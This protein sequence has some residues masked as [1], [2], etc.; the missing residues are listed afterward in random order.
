[1]SRMEGPVKS[2]TRQWLAA[3]SGAALAGHG[4]PRRDQRGLRGQ[5]AATTE[6]PGFAEK[7]AHNF[8]RSFFEHHSKRCNS[9]DANTRFEEAAGELRAK[10]ARMLRKRRHCCWILQ[11]MHQ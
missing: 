5:Q 8:P 11:V 2:C 4:W 9:N 6:L 1:M 7:V 3:D 10:L